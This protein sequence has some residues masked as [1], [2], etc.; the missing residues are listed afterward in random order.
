VTAN[1]FDLI[2]EQWKADLK[3]KDRSAPS[4]YG[5]FEELFNSLRAAAATFEEAHAFL[6]TAVKAHQPAPGLARNTY[7]SL[8]SEGKMGLT[9]EKEFSDKW[10]GDIADWATNAF[11]DTFPRPKTKDEEDDDGEPKVYGNMSIKEYKLQRRYADSYPVLNTEELERKMLSGTYNPIE[12]IAILLG[13]KKDNND[14]T[15]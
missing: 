15:Q 10:N 5:N 2:F 9:T 13:K 1:K 14:D 7:K 4:V 11:Y 3:N 12:D 6:T 8:K